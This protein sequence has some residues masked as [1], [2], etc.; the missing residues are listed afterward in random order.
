MNKL[1]PALLEKGKLKAAELSK[2]EDTITDQVDFIIRQAYKSG[3]ARLD[4]WDWDHHSG[5]GSIGFRWDNIEENGVEYFSC[6]E[7]FP[8]DVMFLTEDGIDWNLAEGCPLEWLFL[9]HDKVTTTINKGVKKYRKKVEDAAEKK[10]LVRKKK[11]DEKKALVA[12]AKDKLSPA[13]RKAL[14]LK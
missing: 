12:A 14:G 11:A 13:E 8:D 10:K 2:I 7:R 3:K 1:T 4:W 5:E 6:A 9:S